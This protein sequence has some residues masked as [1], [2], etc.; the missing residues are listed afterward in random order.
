MRLRTAHNIIVFD[1]NTGTARVGDTTY[2]HVYLRFTAQENIPSEDMIDHS[3]LETEPRVG[4]HIL[5]FTRDQITRQAS[6]IVA[7]E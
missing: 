5:I 1:P 2:E 3:Q 7:I 6:R 4:L